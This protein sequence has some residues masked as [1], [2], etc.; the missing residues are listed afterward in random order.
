MTRCDSLPRSS[1]AFPCDG[2]LKISPDFFRLLNYFT[3]IDRTTNG[4]FKKDMLIVTFA[5]ID[6]W[7]WDFLLL[8]I[9]KKLT[10]TVLPLLSDQDQLKGFLVDLKKLNYYKITT[11]LSFSTKL[12][13]TFDVQLYRE[14]VTGSYGVL[15]LACVEATVTSSNWS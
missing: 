8:S 3:I 4:L 14:S 7:R 1:H 5:P 10:K 2:T 6:S 11:F 12:L 13:V 9:Q 15:S